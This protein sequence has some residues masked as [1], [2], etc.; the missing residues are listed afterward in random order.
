ML[1]AYANQTPNFIP[2]LQVSAVAR[3]Q[4]RALI[5]FKVLKKCLIHF[6]RFACCL[7]CLC[8]CCH[9]LVLHLERN[10]AVGVFSSGFSARLSNLVGAY[11]ELANSLTFGVGEVLSEITMVANICQIC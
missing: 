3:A 10:S 6:P 7:V 5:F 11:Y 2:F 9:A 4:R 1:A 8:E